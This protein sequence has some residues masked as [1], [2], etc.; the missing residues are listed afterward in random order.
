MKYGGLKSEI[1]DQTW[2]SLLLTANNDFV[3]VLILWYSGSAIGSTYAWMFSHTLEKYLKSY[4]LKSG[5]RTPKDIRKYKESGHDLKEIWLDYKSLA[6]T[7]TSKLKLNEAFDQIIDD[8]ST[9]KTKLRYSGFIEYSSDSFLYFY[10][11]LCSFLRYLIVGKSKYRST[12]YGL[13]DI[14]F[15]PMNNSPM[16]DGYGK[17]IVSKMLHLCLEHACSFTN[18]GFVNS[19]GIKD[20]SISNTAIFR[21]DPNCPICDQKLNIDT[22]TLVKYYRDIKPNEMTVNK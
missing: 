5:L 9:I 13:E 2:E 1:K 8:I 22:L 16:S 4:L 18:L 7:T 12:F 15:L 19:M 21:K 20:Y 10:I 6:N 14:H 3:N 11:V 17:I